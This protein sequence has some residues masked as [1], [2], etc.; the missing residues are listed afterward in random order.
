MSK[1]LTVAFWMYGT[2][3][4]NVDPR[5]VTKLYSWDVKLNT[6]NR[7]P[8]FSSGGKYAMVST[9]VPL[10]TWRHVVFTFSSGV[11]KAYM[12]GAPVAL[13]TNTF[14]GTEA[15]PLQ[16]YGLFIGT[17]PA[18]TSSFAGNVDDVRLYNQALSGTDVQA[19]YAGTLH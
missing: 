1:Q 13:S 9:S 15:I 10:N 17:D 16:M 19:L 12:N 7:Y 2:S 18:K 14:T 5:V 8:Q 4:S 6:A 11:V 3:T